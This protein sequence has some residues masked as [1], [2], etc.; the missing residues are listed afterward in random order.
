MFIRKRNQPSQPRLADI[1]DKVTQSGYIFDEIN[2]DLGAAA[3]IIM[4][5]SKRVIM[6][7]GYARRAAAAALYLQGHWKKEGY[8]Y[9][10]S[11]FKSLQINTEH[12]VEF[13]EQALTDA[14]D[15]MQTYH[16]IITAFFVKK[17]ISVA[18]EYE[19]PPGHLDD[20]EL[21]EEVL[22]IAHQEEE[23]SRNTHFYES[24]ESTIVR[25]NL[26]TEPSPPLDQVQI[27]AR[28]KRIV[29]IREIESMLQELSDSDSSKA[30]TM[31]ILPLE[32]GWSLEYHLSPDE[33]DTA[34]ELASQLYDL[35]DGK[36]Q[37]PVSSYRPR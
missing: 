6:A 14:I 24:F 26:L 4:K 10:H 15:F 5:S 31:T 29:R 7:Y 12:S 18:Q 27:E 2:G 25:S 32:E 20:A 1:V 30:F 9:V 33:L 16:H 22:E 23:S 35:M 13:Q 3:D 34:E 37:M 17:L 8:D 36:V 21:I 11:I 28:E 19:V